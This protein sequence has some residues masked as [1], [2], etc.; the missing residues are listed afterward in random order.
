MLN[1]DLEIPATVVVIP[2]RPG[3]GRAATAKRDISLASAV[4]YV[5]EQMP[6]EAKPRAV[7]RTP[8]QSLFI[9]EI[10]ALYERTDFPKPLGRG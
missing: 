6:P 5:V 2:P 7:I 3:A 4:R 9:E 1:V 8:T 10:E